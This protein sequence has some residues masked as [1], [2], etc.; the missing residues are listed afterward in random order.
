MPE[1]RKMK[2]NRF[3]QSLVLFLILVLGTLVQKRPGSAEEIPE[4]AGKIPA[5][6]FSV[7]GGFYEKGFPLTLTVPAGTTV[8]YTLDGDIPEPSGYGSVQYTT[9]IQID[10]VRKQKGKE[11][12]EATVVRAVAVAEN[13][14][15]SEVCTHTYFVAVGM[16]E[17]YKVPVIS[18]VTE[19]EHLYDTDTGIFAN[20]EGRGRQWER[21]A[22]F[23]YFLSDGT[24]ALSMNVG[25]RINGGYSRRFDIKSLRIYARSEYDTQKSFRFDFFSEGMIPAVEKNGE[26]KKIEKFKR[27]LL[28]AGGNESE[29]WETT[30]FRDILAQSLMAGSRL[31]LQSYQ[32]AV[33]YINGKYYGILNIRERQDERY[34]AS[35]YNR[36]ETQFAIFEFEYNKDEKGKV[37]LPEEGEPVFEVAVAEGPE[38]EKAFFDEAYQFVTTCDM[39]LEENYQKAGEYFDI[40]NFIDYLCL[41]NYC[42]NTD[43]P[44][45][46]C[47]AWRY[48]GEPSQEYGLDGK[49]R[50]FVFDLDFGFGLYGQRAEELILPAMVADQWGEQPYRDVLTD[51]FRSFLKNEGFQQ[52]FKV[53]FT[54][55][56]ENEFS[57]RVV[58][59]KIG[60]LS[61]IYQD[62]AKEVYL[63]SDKRHPYEKNI[64]DVAEYAKHRANVM[65]EALEWALDPELQE[66][67]RK[68]QQ[69]R[70]YLIIF[71]VVAG[72]SA[73]G[74]VIGFKK[75]KEKKNKKSGTE[76]GNRSSFL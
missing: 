13:G 37:I 7:P 45:N 26:E 24:R 49:I 38:G 58:L 63:L 31:D 19:E 66:A 34:L 18:V 73:V 64:K 29:A 23:E 51:L 3:V 44:H 17:W 60:K 25:L 65:L 21:P 28:R 6:E 71:S 39:S 72:V 15:R 74:A 48:T 70:K 53:R 35:H 36:E 20:P 41:Q 54:Q 42:G 68:A 75:K 4:T 57:E 40:D 11:L 55:L 14:E 59:E 56:L 27:L 50:W 2:I 67:R 8:Y 76:E 61:A 30:F 43:W 9:P 1:K 33:A 62:L 12:L 22:S 5:P 47:K 52:K 46:N 16:K 10:P 32:P 69:R